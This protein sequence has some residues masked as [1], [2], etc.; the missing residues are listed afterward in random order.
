MR[1]NKRRNNHGSISVSKINRNNPFQVR[2]TIFE[3]GEKKRKSLGYYKTY[4]KGLEALNEFLLNPYD[5]D[6][7]LMTFKDLYEIFYKTKK[8][9]IA[10]S[11]KNNYRFNFNQCQELHHILI[12]EIK[13]PHLQN[14]INKSDI[15]SGS[16]KQLKTFL[17]MLFDYAVQME[18]I[19]IN[20]AKYIKTGKYKPVREKTIFTDAEM[21]RLWENKD[22]YTVKIILLMI[23]TG[24]RIGEVPNIKKDNIDFINGVIRNVGNKTEK[25]KNRIIPIHT[26]ILEVI[27]ELLEISQTDYLICTEV[28]SGNN[29]IH[30]ETIRRHFQK[31]MKLLGMK[32]VPHDTRRTLASILDKSGASETVITDIL[33]HADFKTTKEYYI[34]N[35]EKTI[36]DTMNSIKINKTIN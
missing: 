14:L 34:I 25:A 10:N 35:D 36:K 22:I 26:D 30:K 31:A 23:Y 18:Y 5:I 8:D 19:T 21:I 16:K 7:N 6:S 1:R 2:V 32:H 15:S 13:T 17:S 33:G 12:K 28:Y 29:P 9:N 3:N 11:T 4:Q 27:Q 24:L 20:R